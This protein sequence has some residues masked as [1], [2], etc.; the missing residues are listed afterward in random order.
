MKNVIFSLMAAML[1]VF[2]ANAQT[3]S[4]KYGN[5]PEEQKECKECIS[6]YREYRDQNMQKDA[7]PYWRCAFRT[8]PQSAKTL[9]TDG[10][11]FY[12][13]ILDGIYED[14]TKADMRNAHLDTLMMI[15]DKRIEYFGEE[16]KVLTYK[17]NDLF[18]Y[19]N[20]RAEEANS[21]LKR[22]M[23]LEGMNS[24][25]VAAS[26]YY[27]TLYEM[28]KVDK[29]TKSDLLVEYMPVLEI[30]DYNIARLDSAEGVRYEKAK[31]NLDAFFI[32]IAECDDI[33]RILGERLA[34]TP[35]DIDLNKKALAVMN[36]RDCTDSDLY[37]QVAERVYQDKPTPDAAYSIGIQK[38][39]AKDYTQALKY[40]EEAADLCGD[41]IDLNKYY[42]R[43]GQ[44]ASIL[45]QTSKVRSIA[46]KM[47]QNNPKSGDAYLLLGDAI[48]AAA[49]SCDDGKLGSYGAYWLATD[50][51]AKAKSADRSVADKANQK[52]ASYSK[53][54]PLKID[55]FFNNLDNGDSYTVACFGETTT[56]RSRD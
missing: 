25:A 13:T 29:A 37:L 39:K 43:A 22:S 6:L 54:F 51:F 42:L 26:K 3:D 33:Y 52:I 15:Y 8:C 23:E 55:I 7:L 47:I 2:S 16:G 12:G 34:E 21:M 14:S 10:A 32:K 20:M 27:Q 41:C 38:L 45:G 30:L 17:A 1:M 46:N 49:K 28:Y 40:F 35:N 5:T 44:T 19:D 50:Y 9:Y 11:K 53:Q 36:K 48:A 18:N 4:T 31:N 24:D 56:V